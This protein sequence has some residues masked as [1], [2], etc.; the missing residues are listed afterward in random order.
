[1][2][3]RSYPGQ[4]CSLARAL[5]VVGER[6]TPLIVRDAAVGLCRFDEFRASLGIASNVLAARLDRLCAD[7]VLERHAYQTGP[8][9]FE[10]LLTAKGRELAWALL[11]LMWW[12]D[13]HYPNPT[14]P[15]RL[16]GHAGCDGIVDATLRC[17][18]C[19]RQV[20]WA[21]IEMRLG[22]GLRGGDVS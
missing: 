11:M 14:G 3:Q 8:E 20:D 22:P 4:V 6:W 18:V 19:G 7:G 1:M 21:A 16:A 2:L 5:E 13:K 9:R 15:P 17:S 12:G 10:Y